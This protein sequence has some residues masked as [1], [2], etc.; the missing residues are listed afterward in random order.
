MNL[1][2]TKSKCEMFVVFDEQQKRQKITKTFRQKE[3]QLLIYTTGETVSGNLKIE[4]KDNS[5][6]DFEQITIEFLGQIL[7]VGYDSYI[8]TQ[9]SRQLE[10]KGSLSQS[11]TWE[12]SFPKV[13]KQFES[14]YGRIVTLR[15]FI[16]VTI[17]KKY[18]SNIR[19]E[20]DIFVMNKGHIKENGEPILMEVGIQDCIHLQFEY[21]KSNFHLN[22]VL[23]GKV[24]YLLSRIK[25]NL[26][27]I[28]IIKREIIG[29]G[30]EIEYHNEVVGKFEIM[31]GTPV[32]GESIPIRMF[33]ENLDL[34]PT[35]RR[36]NNKFS[37]RYFVKLTLIDEENKKYFKQSE[38][39]FYRTFLE[40][41]KL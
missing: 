24:F 3:K 14:Y 10:Q 1:F 33:L 39:F 27:E 34:T 5:K 41:M 21:T 22:D 20:F 15:Y 37:V 40:T 35:Y 4:I 9:L 28:S 11:K 26:M 6:I 38:I 19:S 32:K 29:R 7:I 8:F 30:E 17:E 25:V 36:I 16:K 18:G 13:E 12:F 2:K 31:N 23:I